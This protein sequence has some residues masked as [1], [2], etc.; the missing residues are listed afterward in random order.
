MID[1]FG[2]LVSQLKT[3]RLYAKR[4]ESPLKWITEDEFDQHDCKLSEDSGC[5]TCLAYFRQMQAV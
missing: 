5:E 1:I 4:G 3:D 2:N